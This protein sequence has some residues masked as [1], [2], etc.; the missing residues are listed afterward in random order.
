MLILSNMCFAFG[1]LFNQCQSS[2]PFLRDQPHSCEKGEVWVASLSPELKTRLGAAARRGSAP[3]IDTQRA[4][5]IA[6]LHALVQSQ[7]SISPTPI[8]QEHQSELSPPELHTEAEDGFPSQNAV[9]VLQASPVS[10]AYKYRRLSDTSIRPLSETTSENL[11]LPVPSGRRHSDL[12]SLLSLTSH[13][14]QHFAMHKSHMCQACLSLLLLRS[15]EGSSGLPCLVMQGHNCPCDLKHQ[16]PSGGTANVP[17]YGRL[18]GSS[19]CSDFSLLQKSLFNIIGRKSATCHVTPTQSSLL[20][21]SAANRL[22]HSDG[23]GSLKSHLPSSAGDQEPLNYCED[24]FC[25]GEQDVT[26]AVGVV[27]H[28][29]RRAALASHLGLTPA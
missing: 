22:A 4:N 20:H 27:G 1:L 24:R 28:H 21:P 8:V 14:K 16:P 2:S 23:D 26:R 6:Q 10:A 3:V 29:S 12:S 18:K 25:V 9:S 5:H 15:R 19:D 13:H 7:R 17:G 11:T